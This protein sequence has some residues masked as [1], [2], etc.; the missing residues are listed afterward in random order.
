MVSV[1]QKGLGWRSSSGRYWLCGV[2]VAVAVALA[3]GV[4][5]DVLLG[6]AVAVAV[7]VGV[8]VDVCVA[9]G[10]AVGLRMTAVASDWLADTLRPYS[11]SAPLTPAVLRAGS[12]AA[13]PR[14]STLTVVAAPGS[15]QP[16]LYQSSRPCSGSALSGAGAAAT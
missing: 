7:A 13:S 3:V 5:V 11:S 15:S 6:V 12:Q 1:Y 16:R 9:V 8:R 14:S 10:V 4:R 2:D